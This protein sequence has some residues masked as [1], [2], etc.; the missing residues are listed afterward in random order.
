DD[1][2]EVV[3]TADKGGISL[4]TVM[5]HYY[6]IPHVG[7]AEEPMNE[8]YTTLGYMAGITKK[9]KISAMVTGVIY[10]NPGFLIKQATTLDVL[11]K[12]RAYLGLGAAWFEREAVG[13]GFGFPT[14]K[15]RFERLEETLQIA[16]QMWSDN[17]GPFNGKYYQLL[18]T[19]CSPKPIQKP[20]PPIILGGMGETKTLKFVAKY[21]NACNL[22]SRVGEDVLKH[23]INVLKKHC[24]NNNRDFS[25]IEI[26]SQGRI[27]DETTS[28]ELI[29]ELKSLKDL[30]F[31]H[32]H[33][34]IKGLYDLKQLEMVCNEIIPTV[35][36]W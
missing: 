11:S 30:G 13:L 36:D 32:A 5:D 23:K 25:E 8:A 18:E 22:F 28:D 1:F 29:T 21:A 33:F 15:E 2:T 34:S 24:E 6:Q 27:S 17:N 35:S 19:L 3:K 9:A 14:L 7:E 16:K 26:T 20:H 4:I 10:R 31:H 12:G